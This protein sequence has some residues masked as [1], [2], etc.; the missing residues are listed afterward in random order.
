MPNASNAPSVAATDSE[1]RVDCPVIG[2][3]G[4]VGVM[5]LGIGLEPL[6]AQVRATVSTLVTGLALTL[7]AVLATTYFLSSRFSHPLERMINISSKVA[8]GEL[9]FADGAADSALVE[10]HDELG[11]MATALK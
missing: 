5:T 3:H 6:H 2:S 10:G 7:L 8:D 4:P 1:M 11:R 9:S